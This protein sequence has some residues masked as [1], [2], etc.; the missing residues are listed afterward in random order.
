LTNTGS[1]CKIDDAIK[2]A[3]SPIWQIGKKKKE[4]SDGH[5]EG[6]VMRNADVNE[7]EEH[8]SFCLYFLRCL[9]G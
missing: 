1:G 9:I 2:E 4:P 3:T 5:L 8:R 7:S 6:E